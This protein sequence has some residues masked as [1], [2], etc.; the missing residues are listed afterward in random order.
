MES[1][2]AQGSRRGRLSHGLAEEAWGVEDDEAAGG[3]ASGPVSIIVQE[4]K[5]RDEVVN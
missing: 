5:M 2:A 3:R 1:A 4:G